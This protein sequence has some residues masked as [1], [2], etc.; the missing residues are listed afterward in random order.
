MS[1]W[2]EF[3]SNPSNSF[4]DVSLKCLS[5]M[6]S[7]MVEFDKKS[8]HSLRT[9]NAF[10][11]ISQQCSCWDISVLTEVVV[12][13]TSWH[14]HPQNPAKWLVKI[15]ISTFFMFFFK[16][17]TL[18]K[19]GHCPF[20]KDL[21]KKWFKS[22]CQTFYEGCT[23]WTRYILIILSLDCSIIWIWIGF[24]E[25]LYAHWFLFYVGFNLLD[26][27]IAF[28]QLLDFITQI[29]FYSF[30]HTLYL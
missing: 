23:V 4:L 6:S 17:C 29:S 24:T 30:S 14:W 12:W 15:G 11:K 25:T 9:V 13:V 2:T 5:K 26:R 16:V 3:H 28:G 19:I 20:F 10:T 27:S 21:I 1:S 18:L 22:K 7:L 8:L